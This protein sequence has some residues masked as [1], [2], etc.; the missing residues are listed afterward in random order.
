MLLGLLL[1]WAVLL[2]QSPFKWCC[3]PS[4]PCSPSPVGCVLLSSPSFGGGA[5]SPLFCWVALLVFPPLGGVAV[6]SF[7]FSCYCLPSP[8][9]GGPVF[10]P[11]S[12][13][14][15]AWSPL[16]GV[17]FPI[18]SQVVLPSLL[19]VGLLF[20]PSSSVGCCLVSPS[21]AGVA[22]FFCPFG[23]T[24]FPLSSVG[25]CCLVSCFLEWCC[26]SP[27]LWRGAAYWAALSLSS[28]GWC[29]LVFSFWGGVAVFTLCFCL[30]LL[31]FPSCG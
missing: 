2:F 17:A 16:G 4:T 13:G 10:S 3:L 31:S 26:N 1:L 9:L 12:D 14:G 6:F 19:W 20:Y 22:V 7:S 18:S 29:C 23:G 28:G 11:S 15:A 24:T 21:L 27:L 5:F 25:W 30:V 8:P